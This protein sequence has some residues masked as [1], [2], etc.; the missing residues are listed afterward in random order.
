MAIG[1][2]K[3]LQSAGRG[4]VLVVGF[5]ALDQAVAAVRAGTLAATVDQQAAEQG[6]LGVVY[7]ARALNGGDLPPETM[8]ATRLVTGTEYPATH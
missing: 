6:Y 2:L 4:D 8:V 3:Y 7:A 5:D 1:A